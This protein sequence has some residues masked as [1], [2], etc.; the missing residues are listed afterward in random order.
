MTT[1]PNA[2]VK[3][4]DHP[5]EA[6]RSSGAEVDS[7]LTRVKAIAPVSSDHGRL[8]FAMDA[9]MSRQ[10]TWDLALCRPTCSAP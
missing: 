4:K 2:P 7:F 1:Q 6:P 3:K 8:I 9:T 5:V 10:P